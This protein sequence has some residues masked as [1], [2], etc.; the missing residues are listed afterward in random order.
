M[1]KFLLV[2][3]AAL[4]VTASACKAQESA[5]QAGSGV[6]EDETSAPE[7]V[8]EGPEAS[9]EEEE[10]LLFTV[11]ANGHVYTAE[12]CGSEAARYFYDNML[13]LELEMTDLNG[14]EKYYYLEEK[15][16][17]EPEVGGHI[18]KGEIMLFGQSCVMIFYGEVDTGY[19]YTRLGRITD[20]DKLELVLGNSDVTV[21]LKAK[22]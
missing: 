11:R 13:P 18:E 2:L 16:P 1:K 21:K 10:K 7:T 20:T 14:N 4:A 6:A 12:L 8:S 3:L 22:K 9:A 15:L 17:T 5:P 19:S